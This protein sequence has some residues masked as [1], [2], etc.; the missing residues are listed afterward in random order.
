M[1]PHVAKFVCNDQRLIL[2]SFWTL[3]E[4]AQVPFSCIPTL[5]GF[6]FSNTLDS[7][8]SSSCLNEHVKLLPQSLV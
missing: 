7:M 6:Y 4:C 8:V 5:G 3:D 1:L 2:G